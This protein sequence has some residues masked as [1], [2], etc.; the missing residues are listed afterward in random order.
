[1]ILGFTLPFELAFVAI[2]LESFINSGRTVL[3]AGLELAMQALAFVLRFVSSV[4]RETGRFM[5]ML[6]DVLIFAPLAIERWVGSFREGTIRS[7]K[8]RPVPPLKRASGTE[9]AI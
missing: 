4:A 1:M 6:Y 3:G 5:I 9:E 8:L 7:N 2:P